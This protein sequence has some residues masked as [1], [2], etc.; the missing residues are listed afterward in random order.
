M[1]DFKLPFAGYRSYYD[2]TVSSQGTY[3]YYL[4]SSPVSNSTSVY[5]LYMKND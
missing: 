5:A 1:K 4:S 2:V 3:G